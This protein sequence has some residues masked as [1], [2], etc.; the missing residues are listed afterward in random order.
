MVQDRI[1]TIQTIFTHILV[2]YE[3]NIIFVLFLF[4]HSGV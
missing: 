1:I 3:K 2:N 4:K